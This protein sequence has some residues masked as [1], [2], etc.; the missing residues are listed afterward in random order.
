MNP[1][2]DKS[3]LMLYSLGTGLFFPFHEVSVFLLL[4]AFAIAAM[5]YGLASQYF[6]I[7]SLSVYGLLT[8]LLP[9]GVF[10][11]PILIYDFLP[12]SV[13]GTPYLGALITAAALFFYRIRALSFS[14]ILYLLFGM[15]LSCILFYMT[16]R[17]EKLLSTYKKTRDDEVERNLLLRE[18]NQTLLEKQQYEIYAATLKERNRIAREIHD[19]VG[20]MLSRS[21]LMVGALKT[22]SSEPSLKTPLS[23]LDET[24]NT[25]MDNI[26]ESVHDLHD[27][28]VNLKDAVDAIISSFHFCQIRLEYDMGFYLP[29]SIKYCFTAVTK[30]AL[31]N[32]SRHSNAT[33]A[34][35]LMR[36]HPGMYQLII[37]DNGAAC[38]HQITDAQFPGSGHGMGLINIKERAAALNGTVYFHSDRGFEILMTIPKSVDS[39]DSK[40]KR[41]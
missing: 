5:N 37:R 2:A 11:F 16:L 28:S 17:Y 14:F 30:E 35:I 4:C 29:S 9:E 26:R 36:E 39:V 25:A 31:S 22:V 3:L 7:F 27:E 18:K 24:L 23:L 32:I 10:F 21:I 38:T 13:P 40:N 20:H 12:S 33:K 19:N 34:S 8:L 1:F 6:R 15:T 41:N